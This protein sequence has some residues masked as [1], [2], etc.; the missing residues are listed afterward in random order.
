MRLDAAANSYVGGTG[1]AKRPCNQAAAVTS[2][3]TYHHMLTG[4]FLSISAR[5]ASACEGGNSGISRLTNQPAG[6]QQAVALGL[7]VGRQWELVEGRAALLGGALHGAERRRSYPMICGGS[8]PWGSR[9]RDTR[10]L[11]SA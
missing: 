5:L 8:Y 6:H 9:T 3:P 11:A 4:L 1:G 7:S 2:L 10:W